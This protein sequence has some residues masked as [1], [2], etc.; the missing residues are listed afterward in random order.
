MDINRDLTEREKKILDHL[1]VGKWYVDSEF[2]VSAPY[3][4][5]KIAPDIHSKHILV[6]LNWYDGKQQKCYLTA[7]STTFDIEIKYMNT[8]LWNKLEGCV[9]SKASTKDNIHE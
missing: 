1:E 3:M 9:S 2:N 5:T 7:F 4:I 8:P 6:T